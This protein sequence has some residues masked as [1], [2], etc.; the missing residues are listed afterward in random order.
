MRR[1]RVVTATALGAALLSACVR[2]VDVEPTGPTSP[3]VST[4]APASTSSPS[5]TSSPSLHE[6]DLPS[7]L[8]VAISFD[9]PGV[10]LRE[11]D[12]YSGLD[13]DVARYIARH[14]GIDRISFVEGMTDQRETLLA[15]GQADLV[16]SSYSITPER[17][18]EVTF[19]GPY[20]TTGQDLLVSSRSTIRS[21][22]QLR[23]FTVCSV[24][25]STSTSE[26]VDDHPG[27]HLTVQPRVSDCVKLLEEGKVKAVTSD[28]A[29]L[30]GF[31]R[32]SR[33][34]DKLRLSGRSF[35]RERWGVAMRPADSALCEDVSAALEDMVDSGAW[36]KAVR[37]NLATSMLPTSTLR[38]PKLQDCPPP[39]AS[40]SSSSSVTSGTS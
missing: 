34:P 37:S 13:V 23:G 1:A 19:A 36:K 38:P 3:V 32:G 9:Q 26:L 5:G 21:P 8:R 24:Q 16:L 18:D 39:P 11:G 2:P 28:A 14:L 12:T 7:T 15:T 10:G 29:I 25:G 33:A 22:G 27:L 31:A 40:E 4:Q 17:K 20:L 6:T 35:A 30:A